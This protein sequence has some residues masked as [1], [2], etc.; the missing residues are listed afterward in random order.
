MWILMCM[1]DC[2]F[3]LSLFTAWSEGMFLVNLG[4]FYNF[5]NLI[6]TL[7]LKAKS[8]LGWKFSDYLIM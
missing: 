8:T 5:Y 1:V 7:V 3:S 6:S 4:D 2:D